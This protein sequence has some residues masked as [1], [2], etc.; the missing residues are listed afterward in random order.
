[1]QFQIAFSVVD[2]NY[3]AETA[4]YSRTPLIHGE[5]INYRVG[6][7]TYDGDKFVLDETISTH[8]CNETD[9][10]ILAQDFE[11]IEPEVK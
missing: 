3:D 4:H 9:K 1:M 7:W 11:S 8:R 6:V 10:N 2:E 5:F